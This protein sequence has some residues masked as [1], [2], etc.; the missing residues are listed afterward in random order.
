MQDVQGL[1]WLQTLYPDTDVR[2]L[3]NIPTF[4]NNW[5]YD[6]RQLAYDIWKDGGIDEE[7]QRTSL[8]RRTNR[9]CSSVLLFKPAS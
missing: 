9:F 1:I 8:Q 2:R 4:N 6:I 3:T 5:T 7:E